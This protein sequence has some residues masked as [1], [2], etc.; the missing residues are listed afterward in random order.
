M[1]DRPERSQNGLRNG[2][3]EEKTVLEEEEFA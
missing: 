3:G 2:V 1:P